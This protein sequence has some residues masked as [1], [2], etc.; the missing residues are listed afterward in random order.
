[1]IDLS[2]APYIAVAVLVGMVA[3]F[4]LYW[5]W[6]QKV[7]V[8]PEPKVGDYRI[9]LELSEET[10]FLEGELRWNNAILSQ[11]FWLAINRGLSN[12]SAEKWVLDSLD[13]AMKT[14]SVEAHSYAIRQ[15]NTKYAIL[16]LGHSLESTPYSKPIREEGLFRFGPS[17]RFARGRAIIL[18]DK[19]NGFIPVIM[20]PQNL[21]NEEFNLEV[22]DKLSEV[23][24][25]AT[26]IAK[27]GPSYVEVESLKREL[28]MTREHLSRAYAE[29]EKLQA[30]VSSLR[31]LL[32]MKPLEGVSE[33]AGGGLQ[34]VARK[35]GSWL[36]YI[37]VAFL[38]G[39]IGYGLAPQLGWKPESAAFGFAILG[40]LA[41]WW[42]R[43][44]RN[45]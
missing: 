45:R 41:Y 44:R 21:Q 6:T 31:D 1:M 27:H 13:K 14:F 18:N 23:G 17:R 22:L 35:A 3:F 42:F 10:L 38:A 34:A 40:V 11:N 36:P 20:V 9:A 12:P 30:E 25:L 8:T 43:G 29:K 26:S 28:E 33:E 15:G 5:F 19:I 39:L 24:E 16:C 4:I 7:P 32:A 2:Q 37:G